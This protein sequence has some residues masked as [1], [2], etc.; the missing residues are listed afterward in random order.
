MCIEKLCDILSGKDTSLKCVHYRTQYAISS[1]A[2][3]SE[4]DLV[5]SVTL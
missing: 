2:I 1:R 4:Q 5:K 3:V